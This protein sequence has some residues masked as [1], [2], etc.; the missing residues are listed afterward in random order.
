MSVQSAPD[1]RNRSARRGSTILTAIV[2]LALVL[3]LV[4]LML[5]PLE[6]SRGEARRVQC[7]NM[8]KQIAQAL[9]D[10]HDEHGVF[11]PAYLVDAE[12]Q[13]L[14]SWRTLLLPYLDQK[15]L[16]D[17]IDLTRPWNDPVNVKTHKAVSMT[18]DCPAAEIPREY[19]TYLA[20]LADH[21]CLQPTT[22]RKLSEITDGPETT[23][24]IVEVPPDQ[25]VHWMEPQDLEVA[26]FLAWNKETKYSHAGG[27]HA[28]F[29]DG[30]TR[31]LSA[32]TSEQDRRAMVSVDGQD[33]WDE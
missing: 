6:I 20:V 3:L 2:V 1:D 10:Y 24:M 23:L 29:A 27:F 18:F 32:S 31:F 30:H 7:K 17:Q 8:L 21:S 19:T 12:G 22:L 26:E 5:P 16:Y 11:P 14:H 4:L 9:H 15:P 28:A 33:H 25:A 13:R